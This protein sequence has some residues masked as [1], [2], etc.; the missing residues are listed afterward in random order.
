MPWP[1]QLDLGSEE[2]RGVY[3]DDTSSC[4]LAFGTAASEKSG[5]AVKG[6]HVLGV[7][8]VLCDHRW[9]GK[10]AFRSMCMAWLTSC[11]CS[12]QQILVES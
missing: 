4:V 12:F 11:S 9:S 8:S 2:N 7:A 3:A 5:R 6:Y 10:T 1:R